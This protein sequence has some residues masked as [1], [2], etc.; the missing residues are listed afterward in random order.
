MNPTQGTQ[1][2]S[3]PV[4]IFSNWDLCLRSNASAKTWAWTQPGECDYVLRELELFVLCTLSM[5]KTQTFRWKM[6][7][8]ELSLLGAEAPLSFCGARS[9]FRIYF[10]FHPLFNLGGKGRKERKLVFFQHLISVRTFEDA[11]TTIKIL[12]SFVS[13]LWRKS[14]HKQGCCSILFYVHLYSYWKWATRETTGAKALKN[15]KTN[16]VLHFQPEAGYNVSWEKA[17]NRRKCCCKLM[18]TLS[19]IDYNW[20]MYSAY[21]VI[22]WDMATV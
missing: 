13:K 15:W 4:T 11:H 1:F 5:K 21:F 7:H 22:I 19:R 16:A 18:V 6:Y 2:F 8:K 3:C 17:F 10:L 20:L 14:A 12:S 9:W